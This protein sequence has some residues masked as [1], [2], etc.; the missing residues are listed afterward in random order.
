M[1][2]F[3]SLS[4]SA[5]ASA[6]GWSELILLV[7]GAILVLGLVGEYH[8]SE[9]SK[10]YK[11]FEMFVIIGVLGELLADGGIFVFSERLQALS[12]IEVARFNIEAAEARKEAS[13]STARAIAAEGQINDLKATAKGFELQ[14]SAANARANAAEAQIANALV[15]AAQ[16]N[17]RAD[18]AR[19]MAEAERTER[20]RLTVIAAP[21]QLDDNQISEMTNA[22]QPFA[23]KT[24]S[25]VSYSFDVEGALLGR[26]F[27]SVL[28][29][30]G[31]VVT[32]RGPTLAPTGG[33]LLQ[34]VWV[35]GP[36]SERDL[37]SGLR[38]IIRTEGRLATFQT[39]PP[40][41]VETTD[42]LSAVIIIGI[43]LYR[44]AA[45]RN[46]RIVQ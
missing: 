3:F 37:I 26:Q 34:G 41:R 12:D 5:A 19:A 2:Y 21:R 15:R 7:F 16:A 32:D 17:A 4:K 24:V 9:T 1:E 43:R 45:P 44:A 42:G 38:T 30:A 28:Q 25:V 31:V 20:V 36:S 35:Y 46:L 14:I 13:A 11:R 6:L 18:E 22:L 33:D 27:V 23:G 8:A 39:D 29:T 10:W 40:N